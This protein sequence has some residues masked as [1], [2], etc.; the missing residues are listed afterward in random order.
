MKNISYTVGTI[1]SVIT[2]VVTSLCISHYFWNKVV[3]DIVATCEAH[4]KKIKRRREEE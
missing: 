2:R 3:P 1:C 4:V